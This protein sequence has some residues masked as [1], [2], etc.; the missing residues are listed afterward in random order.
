MINETIPDHQAVYV[1]SAAQGGRRRDVAMDAEQ[2]NVMALVDGHRTVEQICRDSHLG[3]EE[4]LRRLA[5]LK[6][7]G[8][9][10]PADTR[11]DTATAAT[12]ESLERMVSRLADLFEAYLTEKS[13][14][15]RPHPRFTSREVGEQS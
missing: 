15:T 9:I 12:G 14:A 11:P 1:I 3:Y 10:T 8:L 6:L 7:A 2:W 4:T 13:A 5:Q